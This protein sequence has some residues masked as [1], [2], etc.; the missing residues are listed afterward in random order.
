[1]EMRTH[2]GNLILALLVCLACTTIRWAPDP[3]GARQIAPWKPVPELEPRLLDPDDVT[4]QRE[5]L[6]V[7][8][9]WILDIYT[10]FHARD[11]D[12]FRVLFPGS[13]SDEVVAHLLIPPGAGPHPVV[14]VFPIL[15]GSHVVSEGM[16]K[17]LVRRGYAVARMERRELKLSEARGPEVPSHAFRQAILDARR[18]LDWLVTH[19]R[20]DPERVA[21]AGVSTGAILSLTLMEVDPRVRAGFFL[22]VGGNLAEI[23]YD[24]REKPI[25]IFRKRLCAQHQ[26]ETR[27]AW[28]AFMQPYL[29]PVDPI[30]YADRVD[31]RQ[32]LIVSGRFD[33]IIHSKHTKAL[34]QALGQ[35][36]WRRFP[37][38][39]YQFFPFFWWAVGRGSD[40]LDGFFSS[41]ESEAPVQLR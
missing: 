6:T 14:L 29:E 33:R 31:P 21:A 11:Y 37:A 16:A 8:Q 17:A 12:A 23:L 10:L 15:Q 19:P 40:H 32:V 18:L 9:N 13:E 20:L 26:L 4:V 25:R 7:E 34:W 22:M 36:T 27:E 38:G 1:M 30:T 41:R 5:G 3:S 35:P 28:A 2:P 24:S 39:H